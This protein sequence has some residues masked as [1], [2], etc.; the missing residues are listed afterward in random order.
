MRKKLL[1]FLMALCSTI[2]LFGNYTLKITNGNDFCKG[3]NCNNVFTVLICIILF[4]FYGKVL[5]LKATKKELLISILLSTY[6]AAT[7]VLGR[8]I[9]KIGNLDYII[10]SGWSL[11]FY[12]ICFAGI[13]GLFIGAI[14]YILKR[15]QNEFVLDT[16]EYSFFTYNRKSLFIVWGVIL[17]IWAFY[18]IIY[19]PGSC[20]W[21]S[22]YQIAMGH[23]LIPL[24]DAHPFMH[25][26]LVS[27]IIKIG[28]VIFGSTYYGIGFYAFIQMAV[29]AFGISYIIYYMA[30][31][32]IPF[33][34]RLLA[35][36]FYGLNPIIAV[37]SITIVKDVWM[38]LFLSLYM[39]FTIDIIYS[40]NQFF[41]SK[42]KMILFVIN[43]IVILFA[44]NTGVYMLILT[45]PILFVYAKRYW[46][47]LLVLCMVCFVFFGGVRAVV[48]PQ[49]EISKGHVREMLS[50]PLQQIARTVKYHDADLDENEK[51]IINEILPYEKIAELYNPD[52]S[53]NIKNS[54]NEETFKGDIF[55][56]F[57]LWMKLGIKHP[58]TY[59]ESF[60]ANTFGYWHIETDIIYLRG[61]DY[62]GRVYY[63]DEDTGEGIMETFD[64]NF[65]QNKELNP[66]NDVR[67]NF[68]TFINTYIKNIP[69]L[70]LVFNIASYFGLAF[71]LFGVILNK[72]EYK[73]IPL[74]M[75]IA[76]VFILA[77][78]SPV[79]GEMRY[80]YTVV[81]AM[82]IFT[83]FTLFSNKLKSE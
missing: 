57:K 35:L 32:N 34:I 13:C 24:D 77:L 33:G 52:L 61:A 19:F 59:L 63:I 66:F 3:L 9:Q 36:A 26:V 21:D 27:A 69:I 82:P 67:R 53:D 78:I 48:M 15:T 79:N 7:V 73:L 11:L 44:K 70:N 28:T 8:A 14:L 50:V 4:Y 25:T 65:E 18:Y 39:L 43:I 83:V 29:I 49:L 71:I 54:L 75:I 64:E 17:V 60:L 80:A 76:A 5:D 81:F 47:K 20:T 23:G 74:F 2:A 22:N 38:T 51:A 31:R 55:K 68:Y 40:P 56:Y 30:K 45:L 41:A 37:W 58:K 72:R 1:A 42:K 6:F 62:E 10:S 16:K 46:K 12:L